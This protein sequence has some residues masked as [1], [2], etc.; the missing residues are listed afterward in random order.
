M[1]VN[2]GYEVVIEP[3]GSLAANLNN[4]PFGGVPWVYVSF[5]FVDGTLSQVYFHNDE[6]RCPYK[7]DQAYEKVKSSLDNKYHSYVIPIQT[8]NNSQLCYYEDPKT[9]VSLQ[10]M[11]RGFV[12]F[13][14]LE[15]DDIYLSEKKQKN[16]ADEL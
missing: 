5:G 2:K 12:K 8:D 4:V 13:I 9:G 11:M 15:Y 1:L 14:S 3:D 10:T 6:R 16:E 7:I